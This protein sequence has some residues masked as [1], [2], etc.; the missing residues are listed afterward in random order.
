M[1]KIKPTNKWIAGGAGMLAAAAMTNAAQA[2]T[3][4]PLLNTLIKKGVLTQQEAEAI[5]S[6]ASTNAITAAASKW[7]ISNG[8]KSIELFGDIRFRYEYRGAEAV[9]STGA[10]VGNLTRD[11]LRYAVRFGIRGDLLD[12]FYYGFRLETSQNSRSPWVTF[13][14]EN[15]FA[16]PGPSAKTSD[17]INIGQAYLG[18][19]PASW[20]D[21][22]VG[23]MP[24]PLYIT[25]MVWDS[26]IMPEGLAERFK[27]TVAGNSLDL[28]A[29]FGQFIYQDITPDHGIG[30]IFPG[31]GN[32]IPFLLAWQLG[33]TYHFNK[34]ISAK[35][36]PVL[37]NY[38]GHGQS[39]G[40]VGFS[41][42]FV[43]Q[44][45]PNGGN[46]PAGTTSTAS[47]PLLN[48]TGI[49][50][51]LVLEVPGEIN[52]PIGKLNGRVFGD[53]GYN[54]RG[55]DR[56][57]A[58]AAAAAAAPPPG[59][60]PFPVQ[61]GQNKAYQVGFGVGNSPPSAYGP[62]A[63]V[64]YGSVAKKGS[65]EARTYWQH[66]E[67][68]AL[69]VNLVDSDFFEGRGNLEGVYAALGYNVSDNVIATVRGGYAD[70]INKKLGTGGINQDLPWLN[71]ITRYKLL[72][73]DLTYRF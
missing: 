56:A 64:V 6:E 46:Y 58:A 49:N 14:D 55:N 36:A 63:G 20:V 54:F 41:N 1:G 72:Q 28:F 50:D 22:T 31:T 10:N 62:M 51:L 27:F 21:L 30:G 37:Y 70:R 26:D 53:F 73:V 19:R 16:F 47:A 34:E 15:S 42:P 59:P 57:T 68:Y 67:Q 24:N 4:D 5:K 23:R 44:G 25:P 8:I 43:G 60:Y 13:G 11:R 35:I 18:W 33:A 9:D 12:N 61:T 7:K 39:P 45:G 66:I 32:N 65:W 3:S 40:G 69:D 29:N 17:G 71:P 52:F 48:Q 38:T 2:Q